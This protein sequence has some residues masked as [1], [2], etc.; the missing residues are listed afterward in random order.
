VIVIP[1]GMLMGGA[2]TNQAERE[3]RRHI[4]A[5]QAKILLDLRDTTHLASVAIGMLAGVYTSATNRGLRVWVCNAERK[6]TNVL[7]IVK[8]VQVMNLFDTR[9]EALEAFAKV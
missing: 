5:G 9:A 1:K 4:E 6:I 8:L 2:E 7:A 3:L